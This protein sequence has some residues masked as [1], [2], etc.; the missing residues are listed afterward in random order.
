M[1]GLVDQFG[2]PLI[3]QNAMPTFPQNQVSEFPDMIQNFGLCDSTGIY[4]FNPF[5][6]PENQQFPGSAPVEKIDTVFKNMRWYLVS[7]FR[8][9]LNQLFVEI[10]LVNTICTVP[11]QDGFRGGVEIKSKQLDEE[12]IEELQISLDR[13][14]DLGNIAQANVWNRLFGGA[15]LLTLT[16]QDPME[17]LD[18]E[19]IN[20]DTPLE[21]RAVDMWELFWDKQNTEGYDPAIQ[22]QDFEYY[23]YYGEQVHKSRVMR[24]KGLIS[25]SFIRPRLRGWGFSVVEILVRSINQYLKATDLGFQVLDEF[26]IDVFKIKNLV[27]TLMSPNGQQ[28]IFSRVQQA[29]YQKNY[30]NALV[31]DSE[32]DWD[33]KQLS[34]GGLAETMAG[35]RMQVA[36]DMR[37]PLTKLFG[38]SAAGFNSGEDD[39][40]VYNAMVESEVRNK[41]KYQVLRVCEIKCQK[42]F[43][44]IPDDLSV[45]FKP[46]RVL[47]AEQEENVKTQ[48]F[49]RLLAA[50]SAGELS[51]Y[52]FREACNKGNLFDITLDN[53]GDVL[54]P[55]DPE[56]REVVK[57]GLQNPYNPV[58]DINDPGADRADTRQLRAYEYG[59]IPKGP[60]K[61]DLGSE[62]KQDRVPKT[63]GADDRPVY[64]QG[65]KYPEAAKLISKWLKEPDPIYNSDWEESKHPRDKSGQFGKGGNRKKK[66]V[67]SAK[68]FSRDDLPS[69][70]EIPAQHVPSAESG[71]ETGENHRLN[72]VAEIQ[73]AVKDNKVVGHLGI[74]EDGSV[75]AVYVDESYRGKGIAEELYT[76]Y[77]KTSGYLKSDDP[78]AME[79][80]AKKL[81]EKLRSK[82]PDEISKTKDGWIWK[83]KK[84][85]SAAF[86]RASYEADGG[87]SWMDP[88]RIKLIETLTFSDPTLWKE[89]KQQAKGNIAYAAWLYKKR[90]GSLR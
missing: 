5:G 48:K 50:K 18:V 60:M 47:S 73:Y 74:D 34:F 3:L 24:L 87:D 49:N 32:D 36:A 23:N 88:R 19:A 15:G 55:N 66:E 46:L 57:E 26:K 84:E 30:Q 29:N 27:N 62:H 4:Q 68:V 10:G 59:G 80:A 79:P 9:I 77:V 40:E 43:G 72:T 67:K 82:H 8:Q 22:T 1:S 39:I 7:N 31:M 17:P 86:D 44:F 75:K 37:M 70:V 2:N 83:T 90:H 54:N 61:R 45:T 76:N 71:D 81:W 14:D 16:D 42:L 52:E 51:T 78:D 85:N 25:P 35:I 11:V 65:K 63:P 41:A 53:A 13:D 89:C 21:F 69:D 56:I 33:H 12:Q 20:S 6:F 58:D 64:N 38:I 28:K